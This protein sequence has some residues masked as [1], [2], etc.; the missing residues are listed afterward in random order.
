M[1]L[2]TG[3]RWTILAGL[4][5]VLAVACPPADDEQRWIVSTNRG[6]LTDAQARGT[7]V[8][9]EVLCEIW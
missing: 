5:I 6:V 1:T 7:R 2:G 3:L 9:G 8:G 4:L